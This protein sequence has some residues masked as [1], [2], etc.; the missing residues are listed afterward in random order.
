MGIDW[1][2]HHSTERNTLRMAKHRG[3]KHPIATQRNPPYP[4]QLIQSLMADT[5]KICITWAYGN[6]EY[7][8]WGHEYQHGYSYVS[9]HGPLQRA[10]SG[11][12]GNGRED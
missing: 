6:M 1:S 8:V 11:N 9:M 7:G 4:P 10:A 5:K 2:A 3:A 12:G